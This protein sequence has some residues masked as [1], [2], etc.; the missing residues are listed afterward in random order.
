MTTNKPEVVA[1]IIPDGSIYKRAAVADLARR[2]GEQPKPLIRQSD[3]IAEVSKLVA[4]IPR[5]ISVDDRLPEPGLLV[6]VYTPPQPGD[7][8]GSLRI[9]FDALCPESD[10]P[11]CPLRR[12][13][14][15]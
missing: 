4:A 11:Y 2:S 10:T 9:D 3:H 8:D 13:V 15:A 12:P 7:Y 1:W 5:W 6:M 14:C